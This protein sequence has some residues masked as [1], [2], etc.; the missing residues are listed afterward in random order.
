M[1]T[2]PWYTPFIQGLTVE[3]T[4]NTSLTIAPGSCVSDEVQGYGNQL[5]QLDE[6]VVLDCT[7]DGVNGVQSGALAAS[8]LY[9]LYAIKST[10]EG[11][12]G[13]YAARDDEDLYLP[14]NYNAKFRIL[15]FTTDGSSFI[16]KGYQTGV[17]S[18]RTWTYDVPVSVLSAGTSATYVA[19]DL[20]AYLP[21]VEKNSMALIKGSFT[22]NASGDIA[23]FAQGDSAA[24]AGQ[25]VITGFEA[26]KVAIET[27][28]V[29]VSTDLEIQYK[30]TAS[31]SLGAALAGYV[32][33]LI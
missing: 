31:G 18:D 21:D 13:V 26:T 5:I 16:R 10:N 23:T 25:A 6:E 33:Q 32:D 7:V 29:P 2:T 24:T 30:V 22:P 27:V 15:S 20:A 9:H 3:W 17:S 11:T 12:S 4:S 8:K 28:Q 1:L 14:Q 19:I